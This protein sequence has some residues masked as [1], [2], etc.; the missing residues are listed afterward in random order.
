MQAIPANEL[1]TR[2]IGAIS[3]ALQHDPEVG[4]SVRGEL[5]YVVMDL[6]QFQH[7]RECELEV[8]LQASRADLAAG[9]AVSESVDAHL[10]RLDALGDPDADRAGA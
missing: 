5:R 4:L 10:A 7:L 1:K 2:G 9:R 8:A 6:A 3:K